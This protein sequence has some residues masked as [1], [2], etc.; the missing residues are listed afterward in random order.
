[1]ISQGHRNIW[2]I[3]NQRLPWFA[4]CARGY[5]QAMEEADLEPR[6]SE[7]GSEDRELGYL[8]VKALLSQRRTAYGSFCWYRSSCFR[9]LP[10]VTGIGHSHPR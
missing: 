5:L 10:G 2:Y 6:F 8:A 1:M 4:R 3:G 9:R 7:I